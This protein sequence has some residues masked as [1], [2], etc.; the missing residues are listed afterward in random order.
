MRPH[1]SV[2]RT[3][4]PKDKRCKDPVLLSFIKEE[5]REPHLYNYGMARPNLKAETLDTAKFNRDITTCAR[6]DSTIYA[7]AVEIVIGLLQPGFAET[8]YPPV[9]L[10]E[11]CLHLNKTTSPGWPWNR[12]YLT[13]SDF[14]LNENVH[15]HVERVASGG[16]S[17]WA[18]SGK[19][20]PKTIEKLESDNMRSFVCGPVEL[21]I[22][23]IM[24]THRWKQDLCRNWRKIPIT[25]GIDIF[26][27]GWQ[28][29]V[30]RRRFESWPSDRP[31]WDASFLPEGFDAVHDVISYFLTA[32]GQSMLQ[33]VQQ[34]H[35]CGPILLRN[36]RGGVRRCG[37][38]S[39]GSLTIEENSIFNLFVLIY[40]IIDLRHMRN[41]ATTLDDVKDNLDVDVHGDDTAHGCADDWIDYCKPSA[42]NA[43]WASKG[44][45]FLMDNWEDDRFD[46][47]QSE[48]LSMITANVRGAMLPRLKGRNKV[49]AS[50]ALGAA[51]ST[52][53]G[54][55]EPEYRLA[56]AWQIVTVTY[57]DQEF[58]HRMVR[59]VD[60][61][62]RHLFAK[63]G[64]N[65][66]SLH[67][68]A[69]FRRS[70]QQLFDL[71]TKSPL[72]VR[73]FEA[74]EHSCNVELLATRELMALLGEIRNVG[75]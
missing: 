34:E 36:G 47:S 58:W 27:G 25:E 49:I 43:Y 5:F 50:L 70:G 22:L 30:Q 19:E 2:D 16:T 3:S 24:A 41:L 74:E 39:G 73:L 56:R 38:P 14:L 4:F 1:Y 63:H 35:R 9:S 66:A 20:E 12:K 52:P 60:K 68:A 55:S 11:A 8:K 53:L 32:E 75:L 40:S 28:F 15:A 54:M 7:Q 26:H 59:V 37:E 6:F 62:E 23:G 13:K 31:K 44:W 61:Y 69:K 67:K 46:P 33:R 17:F 71:Y 45:H 64:A 42:L 48:Y 10:E 21:N 18:V 72:G 29:L 65:D 51:K 57:P